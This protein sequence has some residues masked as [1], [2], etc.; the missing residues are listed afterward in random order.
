MVY[1]K[2][3]EKMKKTTLILAAITWVL[4]LYAFDGPYYDPSSEVVVEGRVVDIKL[5]PPAHDGDT[6]LQLKIATESGKNMEVYVCPA[7][8]VKVITPKSE[9][10]VKPGESVSVN[11]PGTEVYVEIPM[12]RKFRFRVGE[13][14]RIK[15]AI[16]ENGEN[17]LILAREMIREREQLRLRDKN[18]FPLWLMQRR[19]MHMMYNPEK[20][21]TVK[22]RVVEVREVASPR[23]FYPLIEAVVE[24]KNGKKINVML[25][26]SWYMEESVKIGDEI[27][28]TGSFAMMKE[29]EVVICRELRNERLNMRL[30]LR[31]EE[32]FPMWMGGR[33]HHGM[34]PGHM[35]GMME[36][37]PGR[38]G[39]N[40]R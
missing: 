8:Y 13:R 32:G 12:Q 31:N 17:R 10:E 23:G 38:Y 21:T 2:G 11:T 3:G 27:E 36:R 26:P 24:T 5:A 6:L 35:G 20:E 7:R 18:G 19:R 22:G 37:G 34:G 29:G 15:G 4:G 33:P 30:Q 25:G 28:V 40:W 16:V 14:V 1:E 9:I 39:P